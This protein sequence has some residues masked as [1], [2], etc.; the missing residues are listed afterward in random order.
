[1]Q[2]LDVKTNNCGEFFADFIDHTSLYLE[3]LGISEDKAN[4]AA[5]NIATQLSETFSGETFYVSK[6]PKIF[7]K[8]LAMYNDLKHM[9]YADVDKKYGVSK[10]YSL[11]VAQKINAARK[12]RRELKESA[13]I[14]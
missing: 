2:T 13:K 6:K 5:L 12:H 1:M 9:H 7:A 10:G 4:N 11:K 14:Q 8:Q 3:K